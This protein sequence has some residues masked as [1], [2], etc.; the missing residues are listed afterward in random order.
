VDAYGNL[1]IGDASNNRIRKINTNGIITTIAG[2][3]SAAYS[4]DGGAATN[5]SLYF[6]E[7]YPNMAFD[8]YGNLFIADNGNHRV[9]EVNT[10]GI[11]TTV[12]GDGTNVFSGDGG[13]ATNAGFRLPSGVAVDAF[14]NLFIGDLFS[15]RVRRVTYQGP[16]LPVVNVTAANAGNY[17]VIVTGAN[18]SVTSSVVALNVMLPPIA[19]VFDPSGGTFNLAWSAVSNLTYQ[20]QYN[21]DLSSTN[22]I[23][24]GSPITATNGSVST[25]DAFSSD[26]QRFYRVRLVQ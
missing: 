16:T 13:V 23:D 1:F 26:V 25:T 10:N 7:T 11:I 8:A 9:R 19:T 5:A 2:N 12:A 18:G 3:G 6:S 24:L 14:G 22:W 20:L 17:Q 21:L 4:G 15:A